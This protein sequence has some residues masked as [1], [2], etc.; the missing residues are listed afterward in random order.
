MLQWWI[1]AVCRYSIESAKHTKKPIRFENVN[2]QLPGSKKIDKL[3]SQNNFVM[4]RNSLFSFVNLIQNN[5]LN[6]PNHIHNVAVSVI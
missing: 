5:A 6:K 2:L 1:C 3:I 4:P